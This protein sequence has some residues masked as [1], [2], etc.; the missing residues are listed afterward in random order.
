M[1][2]VSIKLNNANKVISIWHIVGSQY[3]LAVII[4][5]ISSS[6]NFQRFPSYIILAIKFPRY[7]W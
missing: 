7:P 6:I 4:I 1:H 2:V 3:M 5:T